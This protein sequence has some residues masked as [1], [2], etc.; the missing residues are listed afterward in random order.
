[1]KKWLATVLIA[2]A[3]AGCGS[4]YSTDAGSDEFKITVGPGTHPTYTWTG[5]T[6]QSVSVVRVSAPGVI[7]WGIASPQAMSIPSPVTHGG[8]VTGA[9]LTGNTEPGLTAGVAYRVSVVRNDSKN[10]FKD[11]TP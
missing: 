8:A 4:D 9:V 11:F 1:M 2:V 3:V 5:G 6:A 10:A 7:V